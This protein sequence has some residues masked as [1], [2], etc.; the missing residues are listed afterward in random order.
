MACQ[1]FL[2]YNYGIMWKSLA[3]LALVLAAT[4]KPLPVNGGQPQQQTQAQ[5]NE[6][7]PD[8][9]AA[10][11]A[12]VEK[13]NAAN[14]Q[15]YAYYKAHPKEYFHAA[16]APVNLANW[17]LA[18]LGMIG[19]ILAGLTVWSIK[20]QAD[21][22]KQSADIGRGATVP[23]LRILNFDMGGSDPLVDH[24]MEL[25]V[26]NYGAT[27]AILDALYISFDD[28]ERYPTG[29]GESLSYSDPGGR[30]VT[31]NSEVVIQSSPYICLV[32]PDLIHR[33]RREQRSIYAHGRLK[34][35]DVF[36]S[37][38]RS[39]RFSV[40]L[41]QRQNGTIHCQITGQWN[42]YEKP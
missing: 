37:P 24:E 16:V 41:N 30:A 31:A 25:T 23:T 19:G 3:I 12:E 42:E 20:R 2:Q 10:P 6:P 15:R 39:L 32:S 29:E 28:G 13:E 26:R 36:D 9:Q 21:L 40:H 27:P 4:Q 11:A 5:T 7:K 34:Y 22:M 17:V 14:A 38:T 1:V 35:L 18:F 8:A 33:F